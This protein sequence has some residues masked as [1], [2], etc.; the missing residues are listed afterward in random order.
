MTS[1]RAA[2]E[3]QVADTKYVNELTITLIKHHD[4]ILKVRRSHNTC[5]KDW[6]YE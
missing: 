3:K 2:I 5:C 1:D 4:T 6:Y